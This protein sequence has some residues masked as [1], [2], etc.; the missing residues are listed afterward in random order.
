MPQE[1]ESMISFS[2]RVFGLHVSEELAAKR[3]AFC[4]AR[5]QF[6]CSNDCPIYQ[7][8]CVKGL[9]CNQALDLYP[10]ECSKLTE[11]R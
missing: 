7:I 5:N 10:D 2:N 8:Y 3:D 9:S 4:P 1:K 11:S 6:H